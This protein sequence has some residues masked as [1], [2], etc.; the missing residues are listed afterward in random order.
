MDS[1]YTPILAAEHLLV[2]KLVFDRP[3]DWLDIEQILLLNQDLDRN[4]VDEWVRRIAG[5]DD[6]RAQRLDELW[7]RSSG[8]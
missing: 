4:E 5:P 8:G 3:R 1:G 7:Q 6:P 2:C